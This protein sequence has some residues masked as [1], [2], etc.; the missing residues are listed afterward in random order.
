MDYIFLSTVHSLQVHSKGFPNKICVN[1]IEDLC[2]AYAFRLRCIDTYNKIKTFLRNDDDCIGRSG[3]T[4]TNEIKSST[5]TND[6]S[7][8][9]NSVFIKIEDAEEPK[10][11]SYVNSSSDFER[12][13]LGQQI[14]KSA[15]PSSQSLGEQTDDTASDHSNDEFYELLDVYEVDFRTF[16]YL[17]YYSNGMH[18][19]FVGVILGCGREWT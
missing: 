13:A 15:T 3:G 7:S 18:A 6:H 2:S 19:Y 14:E 17:E 10:T 11:Y 16:E 9:Q 4:T 5:S 8:Q 12:S 1:C